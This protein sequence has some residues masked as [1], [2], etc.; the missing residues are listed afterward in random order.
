MSADKRDF[1][2]F[3]SFPGKVNKDTN[4]Y[5]FPK[6]FKTDAS[7][8]V[9]EWAI[10]IRIIKE[11]SK[12]N[13]TKSQNWNTT[14]EDQ[15][16]I[17]DK[18]FEQNSEI[19]GSLVELWTESGISGM[20]I[21]RSAATYIDD[22]NIGK[23]NQRNAFQQALIAARG[24]YL[25]KIDEGSAEIDAFAEQMSGLNIAPTN[26]K[27]YPMLAKKYED[28]ETKIKY[29]V[30]IQP[31]LDGVRAL[32]YLNSMESPTKENVVLYSRQQKDWPN[33]SSN[34]NIRECLLPILIKYYDREKSESVFLDGEFYEQN[35]SL[36]SI[37]KIV[38][39]QEGGLMQYHIYDMF[40]PSYEK[41]PFSTRTQTLA[42]IYADLTPK[43]Q[44]YV[45]L[46]PTHIANTEI[47]NNKLYADYLDKKYEGIIIR[48]SDGPYLKSSIKKSEELRSK[49]LLKRKP[50]LT[51]EFEVVDYTEGEKGKD[52]GAIV[53]ICQTGDK[54][55]HVVPKLSY[56]ERYKIFKECKSKFKSKY[57]GR[58][59]MCEYRSLSDDNIP[60]QAK[61]ID[62]RDVL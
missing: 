28:F 38:R 5:E 51:D 35:N 42:K 24:K 60:L 41:E 48:T 57:Q 20:K 53:W 44:Q 31:K 58:L 13:E 12:S 21:S 8:K 61:G 11:D 30:Y 33:N 50:L 19:E 15:V 18:Y 52:V 36:Q 27:F 40:Y 22:K 47:M 4:N 6:L 1:A 14:I 39:G 55:F 23:K 43:S 17:K 59:L 62:F 9:R 49:H 2:D 46:V 29:P 7:G 32:A 54:T 3:R 34:N 25:K 26:A 10:Y 16:P 56:L 37:N 45:K